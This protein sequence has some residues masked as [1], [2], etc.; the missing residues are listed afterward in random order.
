MAATRG[1]SPGGACL[2]AGP[3]RGPRLPSTRSSCWRKAATPAGRRAGSRHAGDGGPGGGERSGRRGPDPPVLALSA[4]AHRLR[5]PPRRLHAV[6]ALHAA[7]RPAAGAAG[8][9]RGGARLLPD[10]RSPPRPPPSRGASAPASSIS[11][12]PSPSAARPSRRS[13]CEPVYVEEGARVYRIARERYSST[14]STLIFSERRNFLSRGV[15]LSGD[16]LALLDAE[17]EGRDL[18][19]LAA[20]GLVE[21]DGG[22]ED[23]GDL[24]ALGLDPV[25]AVGDLRRLG[26]RPLDGGAEVLDHPLDVFAARGIRSLHRSTPLRDTR[27]RLWGVA[28]SAVKPGPRHA[29]VARDGDASAGRPPA[30]LGRPSTGLQD[31]PEHRDGRSESRDV[32]LSPA[33]STLRGTGGASGPCG[34]TR[35]S[36]PPPSRTVATATCWSRAPPASRS[37][38]TCPTQIGYD[39]DDPHSTGEV[40]RVGVA[41]D[42]LEDMEVAPR[43]HPPRTRCPRR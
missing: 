11:T 42:S 38:S 17:V 12:G 31:V 19:G 3:R 36:P 35:A 10:R 13:S 2:A 6:H 25:Q 27:E 33:A 28:R 21:A 37:P 32:T 26:E 1:A 30:S 20:A 34:S 7:V 16:G 4:S 8:S 43:G 40:G 22:L 24:V 29:N 41:I 5:R 15:I 18:G 14:S 23:E 9:A 39:S